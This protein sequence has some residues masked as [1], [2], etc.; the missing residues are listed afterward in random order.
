MLDKILNGGQ[1]NGLYNSASRYLFRKYPDKKYIIIGDYKF[2]VLEKYLKAFAEVDYKLVCGTGHEGTCAGLSEA[3]S[4]IPDN[5]RFMLIWCDLIPPDD[6]EIP[7][8]KENIICFLQ[9]HFGK[10]LNPDFGEN[11]K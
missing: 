9:A 6:Y 1:D 10:T 8:T 4:L 3:L 5:E 7:K 11:V 2:D